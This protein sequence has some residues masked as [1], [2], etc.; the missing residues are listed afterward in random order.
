MN[1]KTIGII[2]ALQV[3]L[4][5][6]VTVGDIQKTKEDNNTLVLELQSQLAESNKQIDQ[7]RGEK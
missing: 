5:L 7:C 6:I 3:L 1:N 2:V 4:V